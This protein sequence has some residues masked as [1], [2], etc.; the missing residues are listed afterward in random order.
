M[1][2]TPNNPGDPF[3]E[4]SLRLLGLSDAPTKKYRQKYCHWRTGSKVA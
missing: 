2:Q 3:Q 1:N 4:I